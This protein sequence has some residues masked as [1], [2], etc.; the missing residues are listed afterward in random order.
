MTTIYL[1]LSGATA[2]AQ[3]EGVVTA[4][5]AGIGVYVCWDEHW[6]ELTMTLIC[7]SDAGI[8][9]VPLED[10]E[11]TIPW[12][13]LQRMQFGRNELMLGVEGRSRDGK[14]ILPSEF[15]YCGK[16]LPGARQEQLPRAAQSG[17]GDAVAET[18]TWHQCPEA[19]REFVT[20]VTYDPADTQ[21]SRIAAYASG[22]GGKTNCKPVAIQVGEKTVAGIIPQREQEFVSGNRFGILKALD[23]VR[24]INTTDAPNVRDLGGWACD[25]GT[26]KYGLLFRGGEPTA[27]DRAVLVGE[28]DVRH[29][30]NLRGSESATTESPL[31]VDIYFTKAMEYNWYTAKVNEAWKTNIRCVFDAVAHREPVYF[32]CYAGADRT[33]TLACVLEGLLGM[34]RSDIDKDYEL[35]CFSTGTDSDSNARR[36]NEAEWQELMNQIATFDGESFRDQCISFVLALGF[37]ISQINDYRK[38]MIDGAPKTVEKP[39]APDSGDYTNLL[40]AALGNDG[41]IMRNT[42]GQALGYADGFYLSGSATNL[43]LNAT[44]VVEDSACFTTGFM[45][46]TKAQANEG[47]PIYIKGVTIDITNGHVRMGAYNGYDASTYHDPVKFSTGDITVEELE[48][49]YYKL[50]PT[51][52]FISAMEKTSVAS[53]FQY[54]RFSFGGSGDGVVVSVGNPISLPS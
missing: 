51:A 31:G 52:N 16:I 17:S 23:P 33:G 22:T 13:A 32:H 5:A 9:A 10:G 42:S 54:V 14:L 28:C 36:R 20:Q 21:T 46:Y 26:V 30:L 40:P 47:T 39:E 7:K 53:D 44:Y 6:D 43:W 34:S 11:A 1:T 15:A 48:N 49:G 50:T 41:S 29:D 38:A 18:I 8:W 3:V 12:E 27:N 19:V 45:P 35:T 37:T 4:G 25:G 2:S 24:W